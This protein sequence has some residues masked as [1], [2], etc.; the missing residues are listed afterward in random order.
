MKNRY[1]VCAMATLLAV[2]S[3]AN[4]QD[5]PSNQLTLYAKYRPAMLA[6]GW[7]PLAQQGV[8]DRNGRPMY[9]YAEVVCGTRLCSADWYGKDGRKVTIVLWRNSADK[10]VLAPQMDFN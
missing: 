10:L 3:T 1:K 7:R 4:S 6:A 8:T 9:V 5:V 2:G